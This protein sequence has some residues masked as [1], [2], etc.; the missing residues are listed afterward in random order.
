MAHGALAFFLASFVTV[1]AFE[2]LLAAE[3]HLAAVSKLFERE[4]DQEAAFGG[5]TDNPQQVLYAWG[6]SCDPSWCSAVPSWA[7]TKASTLI[8]PHTAIFIWLRTHAGPLRQ[9]CSRPVA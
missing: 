5:K 2:V 6:R 3:L 7:G 4:K 9:M 1:L 8:S